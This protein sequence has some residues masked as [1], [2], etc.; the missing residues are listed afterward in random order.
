GLIMATP[1]PDGRR[2]LSAG[3]DRIARGFDA[4]AGALL[5]ELRGHEDTVHYAVFSRDGKQIATASGDKTAPIWNAE[6]GGQM[7]VLRGHQGEVR[8]ID[9]SPD[10]NRIVT[11][12]STS[13]RCMR[14]WDARS[15][16][17]LRT[18]C[19]PASL[20]VVHFSPDGSQILVGDDS[21]IG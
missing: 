5:L 16:A 7:L 3:E 18:H 4:E 6:T 13:E 8:G 15:G 11:A 17:L 1:S 10:G 14:V 19:N 9:F 20:L 21:G 12:G 2:I